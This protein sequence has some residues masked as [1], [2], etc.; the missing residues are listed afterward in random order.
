M[1][2]IPEIVLQK[3]VKDN[4]EKF[5]DHFEGQITYVEWNNDRYPD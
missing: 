2:W 4:M 1:E 5:S 3:Y